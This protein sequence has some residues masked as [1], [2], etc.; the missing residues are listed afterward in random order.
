MND[1]TL[2]EEHFDRLKLAEERLKLR[3]KQAKGQN[4]GEYSYSKA[5]KIKIDNQYCRVC[6][7]LG[8][9][10]TYSIEAHHIVHRSRI[11]SQHPLVHHKDNILP[12]CHHHHQDHHNTIHKIP[13]IVLTTEERVFLNQYGGQA[14]SKKWYTR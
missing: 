3:R 12:V 7:L 6:T 8:Y 13:Y 5:R 11:G 10:N 1:K 9:K 2:I 14:W 4:K